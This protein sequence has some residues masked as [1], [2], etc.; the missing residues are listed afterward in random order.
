MA[1]D[2]AKKVAGALKKGSGRKATRVHTKVHFYKPNTLK[3]ARDPKVLTKSVKA[4]PKMDSF[5]ILKFPLTTESAMKKIEDNNTLVFIVD[6][7]SNKRQ[8]KEAVTKMYQIKAEKVNTLIRLV[9][10]TTSTTTVHLFVCI[11]HN[12]AHGVYIVLCRRCPFL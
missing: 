12:V 11:M 6:M 5:A 7:K 8:I 4:L 3:L 2:K 1:N 9:C 10:H